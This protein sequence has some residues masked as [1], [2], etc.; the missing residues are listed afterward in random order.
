[1]AAASD[2]NHTPQNV[3]ILEDD[4]FSVT[5]L[6][7]TLKEAGYNTVHYSDTDAALESLETLVPDIL[8]SDWSLSGSI[9]AAEVARA[10]RQ[11]N[12]SAQIVFITG[13]QKED[14][15]HELH[16]LEPF[17]FLIKPIDFA[18]LAAVIGLVPAEK[19]E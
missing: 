5:I 15:I 12:P 19:T 10:V 3:L 16:D 18:N 2:K 7:M 11:K 8:L 4:F 17:G 13:H 9:S 14:I 6:E 1:M